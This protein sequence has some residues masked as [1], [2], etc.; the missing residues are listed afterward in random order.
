MAIPAAAR[1]IDRRPSAPTTSWVRKGDPSA[2]TTVTSEAFDFDGLCR[3][4]DVDEPGCGG[5]AVPQ[6]GDEMP[7]LDIPA[8]RGK[9]DLG[10]FEPHFR[11]PPQPPGVVGDTHHPQRGGMSAARLP[12]PERLERG[13]RARQQR[14]GAVVDLVRPPCD[15]RHRHAVMGE[16]Q[17]RDEPGGSAADHRAGSGCWS[18]IVMSALGPSAAIVYHGRR[19]GGKGLSKMS[20][21]GRRRF[22]TGVGQAIL[23]AK[24]IPGERASKMRAYRRLGEALAA[25]LLLLAPAMWNGFPFLQYDSGGYLARWFEGYLV[26]SRSTVYGL[27]AVAGWPLDFWPEV[28]VQAAVAVWII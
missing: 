7:V 28:L 8:E 21:P 10:G 19:D 23:T 5:H 16:R 14:R 4:I 15:Q 24:G 17:R 22:R 26:P 25:I 9:A 2:G 12:Y 13:D 3:G 18:A 11:R 20:Q 27:F 6:C 1:Q